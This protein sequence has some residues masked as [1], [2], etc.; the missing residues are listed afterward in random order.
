[1][2]KGDIK[3]LYGH[4]IYIATIE[5]QRRK[6]RK[7]RINK[8]WL[9]R[10]GYEECDLMPHGQIMAMDNGT[11]WMTKRTYQRLKKQITS[12]SALASAL[13]KREEIR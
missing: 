3:F 4:P 13:E 5:L 11:L 10:Y 2:I 9:K 8:K 6:H 7:K 12:S 1:M